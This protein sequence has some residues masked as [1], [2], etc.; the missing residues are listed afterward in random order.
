MEL[1]AN[2]VQQV[3]VNQDVVF[4]NVVVC[5]NNRSIVHRNDSSLIS[6]RGLTQCQDRA[7]FKV[8]YGGNI[9]VPATGTAGPIS[10]TIAVDGEPLAS[11]TMIYTPAAVDQFGNVFSTVY[12]DVPRGCCNQVSVRNTSAQT[13][14]VQNSNLI[15]T[16]EA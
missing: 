11:T 13:I 3:A 15:V 2:A 8:S 16:R 1:T 7:R 5:N 12:I 9:R 4:T 6:L 14:E 10:L